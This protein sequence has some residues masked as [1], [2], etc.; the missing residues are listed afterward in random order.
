[1]EQKLSK[2]DRCVNLLPAISMVVLVLVGV[3]MVLF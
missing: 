1:M 3:V 2:Q